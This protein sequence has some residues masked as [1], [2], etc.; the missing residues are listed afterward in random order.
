MVG[1]TEEFAEL[2]IYYTV[3]RV[4]QVF[5]KIQVPSTEP[6]VAVGDETQ[7]L[8]LVVSCAEGCVVSLQS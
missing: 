2:E 3:A 4:V 7:N 5:P 1:A 6:D 8:T